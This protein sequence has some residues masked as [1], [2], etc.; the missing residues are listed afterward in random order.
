MLTFVGIHIEITQYNAL[1]IK[2]ITFPIS[3]RTF[4]P[5]QKLRIVYGFLYGIH[6]HKRGGKV[7]PHKCI[8]AISIYTFV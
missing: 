8:L 2:I 6:Y 1:K 5:P 4:Q 3:A 7:L